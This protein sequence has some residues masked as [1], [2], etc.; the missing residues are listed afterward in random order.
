MGFSIELEAMSLVIIMILA[1]F[2]YD[3]NN[4][5]SRRYHLFNICLIITACAIISN[6]ASCVMMANISA[7]PIT[8]HM[9]ANSI[10]FITIHSC[11]SMVAAYVFTLLFAHMKEQKC[12]KRAL[13]FISISMLIM[14]ILVVVNIWTGCY[15]YFENDIYYRGPLNKLGFVVLG[16]EVFMLCV[17][18]FRN[19][20]NVTPYAKQLV[21]T[22]PVLVIVMMLIQVIFPDV[23]LVGTI[24]AMA[25]LIIFACFQ[26]NRIGRDALTELPNRSSFFKALNSYKVKGLASHIVLVHVCQLDKVNKRY[27]MSGGDTLLYNVARYLEHVSSNYRVYRFGNTHFVMLGDFHSMVEADAITTEI[28]DRFTQPWNISGDK[29]ILQIQ[30]VHL[31]CEAEENDDNTLIEKMDYMLA[32]SKD[33]NESMQMYFSDAVKALYER[34]LYVL[35]EVRK[36]LR[37][38][39]FELYYQPIYFNKEKQFRTAEVLLRLFTEDGT[40]ISPGEFIPIAEENGLGDDI[41]WLV[42]KKAMEFMVEHPDIP[43][44]SIS[45]N[46]SI[47]QMRKSYIDEKIAEMS[48]ISMNMVHKIRIEITEGMITKNPTL[49]TKVMNDLVSGGLNFYLDDFGMGYSNFARVLELP[50]EVVKLDRS[51]MQKIDVDSKSYLVIKSMV[52]ML[53]NAGFIVLAEGLERETQIQKA[54]EI[55]I[56]RVQGFYYAKPMNAQNLIE[57]LKQDS[58]K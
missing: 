24:A 23:M 10:Y 18:Y 42:F 32:Y 1:L 52:D 28:Y 12:Y 6:I 40:A 2:H 36:A 53:H 45:I 43:L 39:T 8:L 16:I 49:A 21:Q 14:T 19:R 35:S 25:N 48:E 58:E 31:K 50:F 9:I 56:D 7:Y 22:V 5:H 4:I 13:A 29:R 44:D 57:F 15:F 55:G 27:G 51:I 20:K 54:L 30:L 3:R 47:Q 34:K 26:N 37:D 33:K 38:E 46:M 11:F 41:S 17:C